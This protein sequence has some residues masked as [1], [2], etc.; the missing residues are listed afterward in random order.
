MSLNEDNLE[1]LNH[2]L[3]IHKLSLM[4][5]KKTSTNQFRMLLKEISL[6]MSYEL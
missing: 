6:L 1:V 2:P 3:I 5:D 4:R